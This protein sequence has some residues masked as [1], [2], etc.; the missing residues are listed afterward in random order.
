MIQR[1]RREK[2]WTE[3]LYLVLFIPEF[4]ASKWRILWIPIKCLD[5]STFN[6]SNF[7]SILPVFSLK[8]YSVVGVS[9]FN[10]FLS[11]ML[12]INPN[13][14]FYTAIFF[15][16]K[17]KSNVNGIRNPVSTFIDQWSQRIMKI[18]QKRSLFLK[19]IVISF[20]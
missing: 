14:L 1:E 9:D 4:I 7:H 3:I 13:I 11:I 15:L 10:L 6:S 20:G 5:D 12:T 16:L 18:L 2:N 8:C 19:K 17:I